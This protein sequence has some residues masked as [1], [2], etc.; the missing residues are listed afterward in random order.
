MKLP[1][2]TLRP[3]NGEMTQWTSFWE[4][5]ESAIHNNKDLSDID[6][7]NYLN[8]L[9]ER[10]AREAISGLALSSAN[11]HEAIAILN[12]RFGNK[13]QISKH[14]DILLNLE[15]VTSSHN[16]RALR[17][18]YDLTESHV[19]SL[20]SLGVESSYGSMLSS[21]LL[22]KLP[23][24]LRLIISGKVSESDWNLDSL[25]KTTE[26]ELIARERVEPKPNQPPQRRNSERGPST[27][28]A[29]VTSINSLSPTC[30]YCQ[31]PHTSNSCTNVTEVDARKQILRKSGRCF[32]CLKRGHLSRDCRSSHK[33]PKC[34]GRH[35][36]SICP[37]S[38]TCDSNQR[39]TTTGASQPALPGVPEASHTTKSGLNP[40]AATFVAPTTFVTMC[41][42]V[43][44]TVLLQTAQTSIYNPSKPQ[45][46]MRVRAILDSGSQRSYVTE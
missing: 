46:S 32:C 17:H 31:Q 24:D 25:L 34:T 39:T 22:N 44:K 11:Y 8:S 40:D 12:K 9:L 3:F 13:Q 35:H 33:C 27:T 30:C 14:M 15:P 6:K 5:Y 18:L 26:E 29:L 41:A 23:S 16:L 37:R 38:Y 28:T 45:L 1:K 19:R 43:D 36:I 42:G 21:V 4:S 10:T 7:F 2:L 20:K